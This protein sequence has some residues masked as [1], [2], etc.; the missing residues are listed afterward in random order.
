MGFKISDMMIG[1][2]LVG[3][4]ITIILSIMASWPT[5]DF[6][7]GDTSSLNNYTGALAPLKSNIDDIKAKQDNVSSSNKIDVI[8]DFFN[9]GY[10]A[11]KLTGNSFVVID[12]LSTQAL[13]DSQLGPA[14]ETFK[15]Y[16][17]VIIIVIIF[18]S[19]ML[20]ILVRAEV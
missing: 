13:Q 10:S 2:L 3:L 15:A 4:F 19:I 12:N 6:Q 14:T 5:D 8:G 9:Q 18:I 7:Q 1:V 11:L 20:T 17:T 16:G